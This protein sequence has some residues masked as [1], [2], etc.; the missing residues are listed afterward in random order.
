MN[1]P[2]QVSHQNPPSPASAS[3]LK[4]LAAFFMLAGLSGGAVADEVSDLKATVNQLLKRIE[5]LEAK[6]AVAAPVSNTPA[7]ASAPAP[8]SPANAV[9]VTASPTGLDVKLYGR[10]DLGLVSSVGS[11]SAGNAVT[12]NRVQQG[13]MASRLGL[14]GSWTFDNSN[15]AIFGLETGLDF[16]KGTAGGGVNEAYA[17][18]GGGSI[19]FNRGATVG[20]VN[21]RYGSIEAGVMYMAP[22]WVMLGADNMSANNYGLSDFSALFSLSRPE[23]MGKYLKG[24]TNNVAVTSV[25]NTVGTLGGANTGTAFFY[26]NSLRYRTP[27]MGPLSGEVSYSMGQQANGKND[28]KKD[29][30]T[31]A[32]NVQYKNGP[33][34]LGYGHMNYQQ[35]NDMAVAPAPSNWTTREQFT[36]ILG[37]RY[38]MGALTVGGSY[39][40]FSV[41]NAGGYG[42]RSYGLSG[43]YDMGPHR[44][45]LSAAHLDYTGAIATGAYGTNTALGADP[46]SD[47]YGLG[48]LYN[49]SKYMSYYTYYQRVNNNSNANLGTLTQRGDTNSFGFSPYAVTV[50]MFLTF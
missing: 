41:S 4:V 38:T 31:W 20:L 43:A 6:G 5:M 12:T 30:A 9:A 37:A 10:A 22:F 8:T 15:K 26:A 49:V 39:T 7:P 32:L 50:G 2:V 21:Q 25:P 16:S 29:G 36:D 46:S 45:E 13:Q 44:I 48:Y 34:Y 17:T 23:A 1:M 11:D 27:T 28:L 35:V 33:L 42:A 19:L 18:N 24:P 40:A 14:T 3:R 47:A